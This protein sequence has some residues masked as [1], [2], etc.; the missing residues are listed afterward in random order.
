MTH[1][2]WTIE[3]KGRKPIQ[4]VTTLA[5]LVEVLRILELPDVAPPEWVT[6]EGG[7]A[8]HGKYTHNEGGDD[9]WSLTW[10]KVGMRI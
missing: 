6:F 7:N 1:Y 8:D 5:G 3:V 4:K 10:T 2:A 9:E